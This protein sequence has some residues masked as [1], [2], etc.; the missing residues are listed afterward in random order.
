MRGS[1]NAAV[2]GVLE[3]AVSARAVPGAVAVVVDSDGPLALAS[4]GT[5]RIDNDG[6]PLEPGARFRIASMTKA[7]TSIAA[8]Q[9]TDDGKLGLD[10]SV[11][12]IVPAWNDLQVLDGWDGDSP[13]LR[14]PTTQATVRQL[15]SHTAGHGYYFLNADLLKYHERTG[16]PHVLTGLKAALG[17]PL[18]TDPGTRWEYGINTDWAGTRR[19]AGVGPDA[20][21]LPGRAPPR[22]AGD[23]R[24]HVR[25]DP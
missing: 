25:G 14:P 9:L 4:A 18:L 10:D 6:T 3:A 16:T 17:A 19:R 2:K 1:L 24:H 20:G 22:P 7:L 23:G 13:R 8:L 11:G 12:S 21:R 15:L 5:T